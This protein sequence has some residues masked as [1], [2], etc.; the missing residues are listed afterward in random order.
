MRVYPGFPPIFHVIT[1]AEYN[2]APSCVIPQIF[3]KYSD[4][5]FH[6]NP[7]SGNG[8]VS[9]GQ[10]DGQTDMTKLVVFFRGFAKEPRNLS[11]VG[12]LVILVVFSTAHVSQPA[13]TNNALTS[14]GRGGEVRVCSIA[15]TC[16]RCGY[17]A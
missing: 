3:E 14:S 1:A 6:E 13:Y 15:V 8:I 7:C 2:V 9:C 17:G 10:I 16:L 12:F 4:I 11:S 5:K